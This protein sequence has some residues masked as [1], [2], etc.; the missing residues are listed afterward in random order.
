MNGDWVPPLSELRARRVIRANGAV[1]LLPNPVSFREI[2][3]LIGATCTDSVRLR[4]LGP[5]TIM[6][7]VDDNGY[8]TR[9]VTKGNVT[10]LVPIKARKPVNDVATALYH[11]N[12]VPGVTHQIVGDVVIVPDDDF[13]GPLK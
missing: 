3:K 4:H 11:A 5:P 2:E 7:I 9:A 6:M 13:G 1:E 8:E 10:T 12:C